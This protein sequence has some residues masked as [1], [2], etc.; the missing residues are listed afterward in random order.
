MEYRQHQHNLRDEPDAD[1]RVR[2][3]GNPI[4]C[5]P[6]AQAAPEVITQQAMTVNAEEMLRDP[7][8]GPAG[9]N[10][11]IFR[12]IVVREEQASVPRRPAPC[13]FG[14]R[15]SIGGHKAAWTMARLI[16]MGILHTV[17]IT[18]AVSQEQLERTSKKSLL[19]FVSVPSS[20][21]Q[22]QSAPSRQTCRSRR[23]VSAS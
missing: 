4:G 21:D 9:K 16:S 1:C 13:L 23:K 5:K 17:R 3:T 11:E 14:D 6:R 18:V 19:W 22:R 7:G 20:A 8:S 10:D 2:R 12:R 15:L